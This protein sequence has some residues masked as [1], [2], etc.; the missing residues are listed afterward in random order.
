MKIKQSGSFV[1]T[2]RFLQTAKVFDPRAIL[3]RYGREGVLALASATPVSTGVTA[4]SWR[5]EITKTSQGYNLVWTNDNMAGNVPV[6]ILLNYGHAT[7]GGTYVKGKKFISPAIRP[8]FKKI[9]DT[10]WKEVTSK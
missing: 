4:N 1:N 8:I 9:A 3:D 2:K 7:R 6:V 10:G 5:Y